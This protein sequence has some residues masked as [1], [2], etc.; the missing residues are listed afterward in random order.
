MCRLPTTD[1]ILIRLF[2]PTRDNMIPRSRIRRAIATSALIAVVFVTAIPAIVFALRESL[3]RTANTTTSVC[4]DRR[5]GEPMVIFSK[6]K[7]GIG[8]ESCLRSFGAGTSTTDMNE[9]S[10]EYV[11]RDK[12]YMH[13]GFPFL[14][15]WIIPTSNEN[16]LELQ[17]RRLYGHIATYQFFPGGARMRVSWIMF[18]LSWACVAIIIFAGEYLFRL[19]LMKYRAHIGRCRHCGYPIRQTVARFMCPE[20]G[21]NK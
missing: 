16:E 18:T 13:V 11:P 17:V 14:W 19:Y 6:R 15:A 4:I 7:S 10:D 2:L 21:A 3:L 12:S 9:R 1:A 20:C 8:I 5:Y